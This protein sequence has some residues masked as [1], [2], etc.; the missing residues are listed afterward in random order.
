[1]RKGSPEAPAEAV[2]AGRADQLA[3]RLRMVEADLAQARKDALTTAM[4]RHE[5]IKLRQA[6]GTAT[7]PDWIV[8]P[9]RGAHNQLTPMAVWS[10]WHWG[11]V[12]RRAQVNGINAYDMDIANARAQRLVSSTV[13]LCENYTVHGEYP[14]IVVNLGGDMVSGTIHD[15]LTATNDKPIMPVVVDL[16][17]VLVRCL[18]EL[19]EH[20]GRVF[21]PCVSGNHG[22]TTMKPMF[23]NAAYTSYDWLLYAL[24]EKHFEDDDR[25]SFQVPEGPDAYYNVW[26]RRFLLTHGD[27]IGVAGGDGIIGAIGPIMRGTF[28]LRGSSS[29]IGLAVDTVIMGHWH[30]YIP[31]MRAI[32]NGSL[33][34]HGEYSLGKLRA[35]PERPQ[36]A[37]WLVHPENGIV[38]HMPVH[39]DDAK[40]TTKQQWLTWAAS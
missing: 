10:D 14:G 22:R 27:K 31:L 2:L 25:V 9:K 8:K 1:M 21:V 5:I 38:S 33:I 39:C 28:K 26:S 11:E 23:K 30:Q 3:H 4:V 18:T 34:G 19:R 15:E 20:F 17:G 40:P 35:E 29:A 32:V 7:P 16:F 12:V 24:L 37:L 36:Q 13:N 6:A